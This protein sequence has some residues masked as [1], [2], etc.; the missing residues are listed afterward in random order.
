MM[1]RSAA[2]GTPEAGLSRSARAG[3]SLC[4]CVYVC[5]YVCIRACVMNVDRTVQKCSKGCISM[6]LCVYVCMNVYVCIHIYVCVC[7]CVCN[8]WEGRTAGLSQSVRVGA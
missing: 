5:M 1:M 7:A 8:G 3:A 2:R 6:S 4:P